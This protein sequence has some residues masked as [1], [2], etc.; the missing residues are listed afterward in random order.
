MVRVEATNIVEF[1]L[2]FTLYI[3][4]TKYNIFSLLAIDVSPKKP[5]VRNKITGNV[6]VI[7]HVQ[8]T[9]LILFRTSDPG[10]FVMAGGE[11]DRD[12][13]SLP[14]F[15]LTVLSSLHASALKLFKTTYQIT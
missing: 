5:S 12:V 2:F 11:G 7:L 1:Y 13:P 9:V 3:L 15:W 10:Y 14:V 8:K 4:V 6:K